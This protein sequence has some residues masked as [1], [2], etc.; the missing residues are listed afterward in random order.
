MGK[1][2]RRREEDN[3]EYEWREAKQKQKR[4]AHTY[5]RRL[6]VYNGEIDGNEMDAYSGTEKQHKVQ[7]LKA[8]IYV[9]GFLLYHR[10]QYILFC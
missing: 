6:P 5:L 4:A 9:K 7:Q 1:K 2:N 10:N 3:S 8:M